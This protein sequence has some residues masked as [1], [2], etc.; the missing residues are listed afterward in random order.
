M[1]RIIGTTHNHTTRLLTG[2]GALFLFGGSGLAAGAT[3]CVG[4]TPS[5][6]STIGAAVAKANPGDTINVAPGTYAEQVTITQ[7]LSL[8][9]TGLTSATI[10]DATGLANGIFINGMSAAPMAG[11]AEVLISGFTVQNANFEGILAVNASDITIVGN[12]VL[13]NNKSLNIA[14][15][16]CPNIS[17]FETSEGEDCGEGIHLMAVDH[18]TVTNNIIENNSGGILISDETGPAYDNLITGNTVQNNP[19]D[20][21]I[22]LASHPSFPITTPAG[23][24]YGVMRNTISQNVVSKNG[25]LVPG[26]GAGVGI[27]APGPGNINSGNVIVNNTLTNNGLPGVTMH[28]HAAPGVAGVPAFL[29]PVNFNDNV[30]VGNRISGNGADTDDAATS[31]PTGINVFSVAPVTG[32]VISQNSFGQEMIDVAFNA[33]SGQ[34][35]VHLNNF[36]NT[37][38][39]VDNIG[40]GTVSAAENWWNC[41]AGPSMAPQYTW[42]LI[43]LQNVCAGVAGPGVTFTPWLSTVFVTNPAP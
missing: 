26:A 13:N 30:I 38:L 34:L 1:E 11:V 20:C 7:S 43:F 27:F 32:T 19:Y 3:L 28:N 17:A 23:A 42:E 5:C 39:G 29:P 10:I 24:P 15:G 8:I 35:N 36:A 25:Y 22:T 33:P 4:G 21:G 6:Y 16:T 14:M 37:G 31:G 12:Q 40:T 41:A 2:I 18:S 9:A